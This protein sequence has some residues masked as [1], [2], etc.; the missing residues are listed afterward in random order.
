LA[1][2][3]ASFFVHFPIFGVTPNLILIAVI[4]LNLFEKPEDY[5]GL[6]G[7]FIAGFFLD[8]FSGSFI[9]FYASIC[10]A[11]SLFMKLVFKRYVWASFG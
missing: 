5:G 9:G 10:L 11:I 8:V 1:L 2:W 3:Q 4:L 6:W 7:S